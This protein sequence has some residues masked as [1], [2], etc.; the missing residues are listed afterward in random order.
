MNMFF[1]SSGV[2]PAITSM[3]H[4]NALQFGVGTSTGQILLY[5]L[6]SSKPLLVKDH[7][8]GLPIKDVVFHPKQD[9]VLSMDQRILK[10]W[11]EGTVSFICH[12]SISLL[13]IL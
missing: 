1:L 7:M 10:I 11:K 3:T 9:L 12:F 6:R 5:D 13:Y 2:I 8:Y 4:K